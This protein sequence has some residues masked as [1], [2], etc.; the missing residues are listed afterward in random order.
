MDSFNGTASLKDD[1]AVL[2]KKPSLSR[3]YLAEL[4]K[5]KKGMTGAIIL[6]LMILVAVSAP[7]IAPHTISTQSVEQQFAAPVFA[8][9]TMQ[10]I[11]GADN[12]G[13]DTLSRTIF[14]TQI[15]LGIA[16]LVIIIAVSVGAALGAIAG[17]A[18]GI[19][20]TI[21]MRVA[22]FQL[23]FP[24]ILLALVFMAILGPGFW[25]LVIALTIAIWA[26]YARLVRG[27]ALKIRELEFVQAAKAI[28]VSNAR[29]IWGHIL[30]NA[31]PAIIVLATLDIAWVII[32]EA[33]LSFLGLGIQPP[34]PSWGV[35]LNEARSYLYE[36]AW[37]TIFPGIALF[38]TCIGINLLGDWLRDTFD[39]KMAKL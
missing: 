12:L 27:E 11:L 24:F 28:G 37:M 9:G 20:D 35:M 3:N 36:S 31:L 34:T 16:F 10:H 22:D 15:S 23:S 2:R 18:G 26:N 33:A 29:I 6:G 8:G 21:I 19:L 4:R 25:S 1:A 39:P 17:Y 30:P 7:V 14:G 38:V 5:S 13:R 32:S